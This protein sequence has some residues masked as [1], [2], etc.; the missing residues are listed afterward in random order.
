MGLGG[1]G[2]W[3]IGVCVRNCETVLSD[4]LEEQGELKDT[5]S[6]AGMDGENDLAAPASPTASERLSSEGGDPGPAPL[7]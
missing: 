6:I 2:G 1:L 5:H 3:G 7:L 4:A